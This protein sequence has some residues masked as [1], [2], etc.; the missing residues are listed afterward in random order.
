MARTRLWTCCCQQITR[1][2]T[3]HAQAHQALPPAY[4]TINVEHVVQ[5]LQNQM[6]TNMR[7]PQHAHADIQH[8]LTMYHAVYRNAKD[9]ARASMQQRLVHL[10]TTAIAGPRHASYV[11]TAFA[12]QSTRRESS[13]RGSR[14]R[15]TQRPR[16]CEM[17]RASAGKHVSAS[18][19]PQ[20]CSTPP[21][22]SSF[23]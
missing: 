13:R 5:H 20:R 6:A 4:P 1:Q 15:A 10:A 19:R 9:I 11:N 17:T 22:A 2:I 8:E 14:S 18:R 3:E 12:C 16:W 23:E 21:F 7:L